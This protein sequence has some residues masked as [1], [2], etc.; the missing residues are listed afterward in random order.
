MQLDLCALDWRNSIVRDYLAR[1][2]TLEQYPY[3]LATLKTRLLGTLDTT[4]D[5]YINAIESR[6]WIKGRGNRENVKDIIRQYVEEVSAGTEYTPLPGQFRDLPADRVIDLTAPLFASAYFP[7]VVPDPDA[8][9]GLA[10]PRTDQNELPMNISYYS[11]LPGVNTGNGV[12]IKAADIPGP[13]YHLYKGPTF[14]LNEW[15]FVYLTASW[16]MQK[17][18]CTLYDPAH[19]DRKW[20]AYCSMKFSGPDY[21]HGKADEPK[22]LFLDRLILV[23]EPD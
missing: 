9:L 19:P 8:A 11:N 7:C 12:S 3:R 6:Y 20:T 1:G 15:T 18:L 17:H 16:Q 22:G 10:V 13:G 2:G 23:R 5:P 4:G 21:P 14:K